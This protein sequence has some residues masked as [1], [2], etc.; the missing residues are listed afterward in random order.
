[1]GR[2]APA[3]DVYGHLLPALDDAVTARLDMA[4]HAPRGLGGRG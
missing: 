3:F 2:A 1:M 4:L